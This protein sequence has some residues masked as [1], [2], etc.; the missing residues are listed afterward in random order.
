MSQNNRLPKKAGKTLVSF[1]QL[2]STD[3]ITPELEGIHLSILAVLELLPDPLYIYDLQ[4]DEVIIS[5]DRLWNIL[6]FSEEEIKNSVIDFFIEKVHPDDLKLFHKDA[7]SWENSHENRITEHEFR[8]RDSRERWQWFSVREKVL[9]RNDQGQPAFI[10]GTLKQ[11]HSQ[12]S[13]EANLFGVHRL[14]GVGCFD[15]IASDNLHFWSDGLFDIFDLPPSAPIPKNGYMEF[16]DEQD[17]EKVGEVFQKDGRIGA[18]VDLEFRIRSSRGNEKSI[19]LIG[20]QIGDRTN[21]NAGFTGVLINV[22][23]KKKA[24]RELRRRT[25]ELERKTQNLEKINQEM[26]RVQNLMVNRELKMVQLKKELRDIK[27][28]A[29]NKDLYDWSEYGISNEDNV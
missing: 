28:K 29:A 25:S 26:E 21:T 5:N 17:R 12:R 20:R 7:R 14:M 8:I 24:E 22:T 16:V 23:E 27:P 13:L 4:T 6:G 11:I 1:N 9:S 15:W 2:T 18:E 3:Q 10:L 19:R